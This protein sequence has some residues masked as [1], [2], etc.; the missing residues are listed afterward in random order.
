MRAHAQCRTGPSYASEA[1]LWTRAEKRRGRLSERGWP[2][3]LDYA[4]LRCGCWQWRDHSRAWRSPAHGHRSMYE[5]GGE[6]SFRNR[7]ALTARVSIHCRPPVLVTPRGDCGSFSMRGEWARLPAA[8]RHVADLSVP[9]ERAPGS[10]AVG[11][12][13]HSNRGG[14]AP[15]RRPPAFPPRHHYHH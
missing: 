4:L 1:P 12:R 8:A 11:T 5:A 13:Q 2:R 15:S 6:R 9:H 10:G 7:A 3:A 14:A